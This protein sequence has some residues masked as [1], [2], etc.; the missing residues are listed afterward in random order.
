M[1]AVPSMLKDRQAAGVELAQ[2]LLSLAAERP[3]VLALPRGG[4]PVGFEIARRLGAPLDVLVVRKVGAPD[5]PEYGLGA[6]V[7][8]GDPWLDEARIR[9]GGYSRGAVG[10]VVAR[11]QEEIARRT[12]EYRAVCPAYKRKDRTVIVVD[13]GAATGGTL[14]AAIQSLRREP[15][16]RVVVA[17]GVAPPEACRDLEKEADQLVVLRCPLAFYAVGQFYTDFRPVHE[18]EVLEILGRGRKPPG[19]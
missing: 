16:R 19:C 15:V 12:R 9:E 2:R 4:V 18:R 11:E 17:L 1:A 6:I 14:R 3:V 5:N 8:G 10:A 7:E 13:D